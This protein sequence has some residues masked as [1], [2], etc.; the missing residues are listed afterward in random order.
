MKL[1]DYCSAC[2]DITCGI[3]Q[4]SELGPKLFILYINDQCKVSKVLKLVLFADDTNIFGTGSDLQILLQEI[5]TELIKFKLWF[6]RKK[7]SLNLNKTKIILFGKC[8]SN[9]Q[10]QIQF[11]GVDIE[12]VSEIKF[13]GVII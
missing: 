10:I 4:G 6:D 3:P 7:L 2:L 8:S 9:T 5:N 12:R 13:L 1:G 11:N